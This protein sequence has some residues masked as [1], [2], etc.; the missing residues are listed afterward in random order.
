MAPKEQ[1]KKSGLTL[2]KLIS[3][4]DVITDALV[5]KVGSGLSYCETLVAP[6]LRAKSTNRNLRSTSGR[7]SGRIAADGSQHPVD[8]KRRTSLTYCAS[9]SS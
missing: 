4:D 5:D 8:C 6:I 7:S 3:Y 9:M 1:E 2:E